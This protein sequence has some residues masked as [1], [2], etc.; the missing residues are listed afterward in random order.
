MSL[1]TSIPRLRL[2]PGVVIIATQLL[3]TGL[4][5]RLDPGTFS[6]FMVSLCAPVIGVLLLAVWWIGF[7]R[8]SPRDR[9]LIPVCFLAVCCATYLFSHKSLTSSRG[10]VSDIPIPMY[11]MIYPLA[12]ATSLGLLWLVLSFRLSWPARRLGLV[13]VP[14]LPGVLFVLL[15]LEG[16][17]G[18]MSPEWAWRWNPSPG[19]DLPPIPPF[20]SISLP[21]PPAEPGPHDWP[22]FRG[23]KRDGRLTGVN[24]ETNWAVR[25][26]REVWRKRLGPGWSSMCVIGPRLFTQEQRGDNEAVMCYEAATG[27]LIWVHQDV[28]RFE[29]THAGV[30][31]RATPTYHAGKL[32]T[33]GGNG[34]LNCLS[35]ATGESIW[36]RQITEDA[37]AKP[38]QWGY[39][40]SPLVWHGIVSVFAGGPE[41]RS[42]LGYVAESGELRWSSGEGVDSY[43]SPQPATIN[44]VE[45]I[46]LSTEKGLS[47]FD[48]VK[49]T[50]LWKHAWLTPNNTR[51]TQ[52]TLAEGKD[53]LFGSGYGIGLRRVSAG[54]DA[55]PSREIWTT[56]AISPYY[57]DLVVHKDH[58][59]GFHE[60]QF[61]TAVRLKD[62]R[63]RWRE[64]GYS[65]GQML[66]LA[67]QGLLLVQTEKGDVA[68]L[69]AN[70]EQLVELGRFSALKGKSWNHPVIA[71]GHLFVRSDQEMACYELTLKP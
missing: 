64:L 11:L 54:S 56:K 19:D 34:L 14:M 15:R 20:P 47:A 13:L 31:P 59:F 7:S 46:L 1:P 61:L 18:N 53:V 16:T 36:S 69:E 25:P 3:V 71:N 2:W 27:E 39:S 35:A 23:P 10:S 44:G 66:L 9:W 40:S 67:E 41:G 57:N 28:A 42:L 48:P 5:V 37:R 6:T 43:C 49:G 58:L 45:Q 24:V 55:G 62:G 60:G 29:E 63:K 65:N 8:V 50:V 70:P 51:V 33:L 68:L 17:D 12:M 4:S 21:S 38:S 22:A 26:P 30:G 52:P 32:Y